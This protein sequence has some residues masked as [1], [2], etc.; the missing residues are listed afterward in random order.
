M[1]GGWR[2]GCWVD[3]MGVPSHDAE[4]SPA[5]VQNPSSTTLPACR[6]GFD[7]CVR[8]AHGRGVDLACDFSGGGSDATGIDQSCYFVQQRSLFSQVRCTE[9]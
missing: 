7:L 9:E 3:P 1:S 4:A 6:A 2:H 8:P 5:R